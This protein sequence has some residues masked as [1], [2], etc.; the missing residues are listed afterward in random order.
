MTRL[1]F[2][3]V[4]ACYLLSVNAQNHDENYWL[5]RSDILVGNEIVRLSVKEMYLDEQTQYKFVVSLD[6]KSQEFY[7]LSSDFIKGSYLEKLVLTKIQANY[8]NL[9]PPVVD[10][11]VNAALV[12]TIVANTRSGGGK[13]SITDRSTLEELLATLAQNHRQKN[14]ETLFKDLR[15]STTD[16]ESGTWLNE[17][18]IA[19]K[20]RIAARRED[21]KKDL[22]ESAKTFL[23]TTLDILARRSTEGPQVG[24]LY[25]KKQVETRWY[26]YD[27][28]PSKNKQLKDSMFHIKEVEVKF[29]YGQLAGIAAKG[30][31]KERGDTVFT[32]HN[33][34]PISYSTKF[35]VSFDYHVIGSIRLYCKDRWLDGYYIRVDELLYNDYK[36]DNYTDNYSPIDTVLVLRPLEPGK[37]IF[38]ERLMDIFQARVYT[39]FVGYDDNNP[40]G[41]V[42]V[43]ISK[44]INMKTKV[45]KERDNINSNEWFRYIIPLVAFN[46]IE[47]NNKYLDISL[48]LNLGN[49]V[50]AIDLIKYTN[51]KA[52]AQQNIYKYGIPEFHSSFTWD[53]GLH[54]LRTGIMQSGETRDTTIYPSGDTTFFMS[55]RTDLSH[56]LSLGFAPVMLSWNLYPHSHYHLSFLYK[57]QFIQELSSDLSITDK[58]NGGKWVHQLGLFGGIRT[59]AA[60]NGEI[61]TRITLDMQVNSWDYNFL[62]G[63][64]G[65][66]FKI[67]SKKP[68][69]KNRAIFN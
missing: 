1:F 5:H 37:V 34:L 44:R 41:L 40:N 68:Q 50:T 17:Q 33:R 56:V 19:A 67:L 63:Q 53:V 49:T 32:F 36:M 12:T 38:R 9:N 39:D 29:E 24:T 58:K 4:F 15:D 2:S 61:F 62:Q 60:G 52:G 35:D 18:L 22:E 21:A 54:V 48:A 26:R 59:G 8:N 31:F 45:I 66:S 28:Y 25:V 46:K 51:F 69:F 16:D 23:D 43:E 30:Y 10:S 65:Y 20:S 11:A 64:I 42:Q 7:I 47:K 57:M 3:A 13:I 6:G 27:E 55:S 14:L